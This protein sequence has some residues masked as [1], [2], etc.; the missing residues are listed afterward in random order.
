MNKY[1]KEYIQS[2]IQDEEE[3]LKEIK[4]AYRK[5]ESDINHKIKR[6]MSEMKKAKESDI[7]DCLII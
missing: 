3:V 4:K 6:L 2:N 7:V 5:A 1:Q